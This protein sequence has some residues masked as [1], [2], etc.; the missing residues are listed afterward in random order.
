M[1]IIKSEVSRERANHHKISPK[2]LPEK[3]KSVYVEEGGCLLKVIYLFVGHL[4]PTAREVRD[5]RF[6]E[7]K[8]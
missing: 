8:S 1:G 6:E 3:E 2:S 5:R 7:R 4:L